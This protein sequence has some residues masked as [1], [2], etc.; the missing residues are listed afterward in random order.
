MATAMDSARASTTARDSAMALGWDRQP[1]AACAALPRERSEPS[2]R[3]QRQA[4][5]TRHWPARV[6]TNVCFEACWGPKAA[7]SGVPRRAL[8]DRSASGGRSVSHGCP[9]RLLHRRRWPH[10]TQFVL[11]SVEGAM[12]PGLYG[13]FG[14]AENPADLGKREVLFKAQR[15]DCTISPSKTKQRAPHLL[16]LDPSDS[17]RCRIQGRSVAGSVAQ[18]GQQTPP[19]VD[20]QVDR[21]AHHPGPLVRLLAE[22]VA[23]L[24]QSQKRFMTNLLGD[25]GI[26]DDEVNRADDQRIEAAVKRLERMAAIGAFGHL[27]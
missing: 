25:V 22:P 3:A 26:E 10:A 6:A 20:R 21:H 15:Q 2:P 14:A 17:R 7:A 27:V 4:R 24:P 12:N 16:T 8:P 11:K 23:V 18:C 19:V 13:G 1:A 5:P 9:S